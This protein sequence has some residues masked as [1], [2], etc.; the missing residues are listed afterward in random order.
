MLKFTRRRI[1][2]SVEE[3]IVTAAIMSDAFLK[4]IYTI[5]DPAYLKS[6]FAQRV[7]KWAIEYYESYEKA[8]KNHIKDIYD[9][10]KNKIEEAEEKI[11]AAFLTKL[12][13]QYEMETQEINDDYYVDT[14][15]K[16]FELRE[17]EITSGNVQKLIEVGKVDEAKEQFEN[18]KKVVRQTSGWYNPFDKKNIIATFEDSNEILFSFPGQLG[19]MIGGFERGWLFS[20]VGKFKGGKSFLLQEI[21]VQALLKRLKVVYVSLEMK[22]RNLDK[23]LYRRLCAM[24]EGDRN[25]IYPAFDCEKNQSGECKKPERKNR[26][27]LLTDDDEIPEFDPES[28]YKPCCVCRK[29]NPKE[30]EFA[31]WFESIKRPPISV[32]AIVKKTNS[33]KQMFG[34]NN[35]RVKTY[36]RFSASIS[37]IKRDIDTLE[38]VEGFVADVIC[39]AEGSL[40]LTNK[41]LIPI[42]KITQE[43]LLWDGENWVSHG[44]VVYKGVKET[45]T[46]AGLTATPE[47]VVWTEKGWRTLESC[48]RLGLFIAKTGDGRKNLR[49]GEDYISDN[50]CE[51]HPGE[52][53]RICFHRMHSLWNK[54]M[55]FI[56]QFMQ[57]NSKRMSKMF[58]TQKI[59]PLVI[60]KDTKQ[61]TSLSKQ[62]KQSMEILR[63]TW[64]RISFFFSSRSMFMDYKKFRYSSRQISR[65]RQNRQ[66][67]SLRTRKHQMVNTFA[68][69]STH[70]E[71]SYY[72]KITPFQTTLSLYYLY[73]RYLK[74][75]FSYNDC[76]TDCS[77]LGKQEKRGELS[78][79]SCKKPVWDIINAGPFHRFTVQGLLV[80]NCIDYA[81]IIKPEGKFG[82]EYEGYDIIWK[83]L[84]GL[85]EERHCLVATGSQVERG[86]ITKAQIEQDGLAG[87]VGQLAHVDLMFALNQTKE[88]KRN[89]L[90]RVNMLVHREREIDEDT[91][92]VL[93]QQLELAQPALDSELVRY[94]ARQSSK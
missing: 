62:R 56:R 44:G 9:I 83:Q 86:T 29:T 68:K 79:R 53:K 4:Q 76:Q 89:K 65:N 67:W 42:E 38:V 94:K 85:A 78:Q 66:R 33:F 84:S 23:R 59:S 81:Q 21:A 57:R 2:S 37:D 80:H 26:I 87:W 58:T 18:Y 12:S 19:E 14:A 25:F 8:P 75:I 77:S 46:H 63:R 47:H 50:T 70:N 82:K 24:A 17:L 16:Y 72:S 27:R 69:Y 13:Q 39:I 49:I 15:L 7:M 52:E 55:D 73:R 34:S 3:K 36:P 74:K 71:K 11:I 1:D 30:Y 31:T 41:G 32:S 6:P 51:T 28:D 48:K 40:V 22:R 20:V 43:H 5:Y 60:S 45:I 61:T 93:L 54:K 91:S 88:E 90:I 35:L 10:E 64:N 92:C